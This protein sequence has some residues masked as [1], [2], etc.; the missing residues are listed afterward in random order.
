MR[1]KA[2]LIILMLFLNSP[3]RDSRMPNESRFIVTAQHKGK[4]E[5][6]ETAARTS[7]E[8]VGKIVYF[9]GAKIIKVEAK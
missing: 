5:T 8:A 1:M 9:Y 7:D 3:V 6:F 2:A 4:I